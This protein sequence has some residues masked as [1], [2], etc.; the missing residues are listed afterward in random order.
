MRFSSLCL[1]ASSLTIPFVSAFADSSPFYSSQKLNGQFPYI[2]ESN[3]LS[4]SINSIANS[5]CNDK[6]STDKIIIYRVSG[7]SK[8]TKQ[9][10]GTYIKHVYYENANDLNLSIN[11][12]CQTKY[13]T[14]SLPQGNDEEQLIIVDIE[15]DET[16]SIDEFLQDEKN[17]KVVIVQGKPSFTKSKIQHNF[18]GRKRTETA[19]TSNEEDYDKLIAEVEEDFKAAESLIAEE[20]EASYVTTFSENKEE[21]ASSSTN[22]KQSN[23]FTK[24]QF[25]TPGIWMSFIVSA[26]LFFIL[27]TALGWMSTVEISYKAFD[28]QIDFEKKTE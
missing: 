21:S 9:S 11:S 15:D 3:Q 7:L 26:F 28:K 13:L 25:F 22:T 17:Y 1:V 5:V 16:H 2:T 12:S 18:L 4:K 6:H 24:Y 27:Y 19:S 10:D 20:E 23:L 8:D 14:N